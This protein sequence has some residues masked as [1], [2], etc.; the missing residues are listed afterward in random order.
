MIY[1]LQR[2]RKKYIGWLRKYDFL[3]KFHGFDFKDIVSILSSLNPC[4]KSLSFI[5]SSLSNYKYQNTIVMTQTHSYVDGSPLLADSD[6][7]RNLWDQRA[8]DEVELH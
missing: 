4:S 7:L 8:F 1:I 2:R 5:W 6:N 3:E